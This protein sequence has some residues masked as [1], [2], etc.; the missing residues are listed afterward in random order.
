MDSYLN[1]IARRKGPHIEF[2]SSHI[3]AKACLDPVA[4]VAFLESLTPPQ[5]FSLATPAIEARFTLAE[6]LGLP[7]EKRWMRL[8]HSMGAWIPL[9]D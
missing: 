3:V 5:D 8:W 6:V 7:P 4:A 1:S 9:D 2:A